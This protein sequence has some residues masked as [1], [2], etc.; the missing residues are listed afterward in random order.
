MK[1]YIVTLFVSLLT[2]A[3]TFAQTRGTGGVRRGGSSLEIR[4][5]VKERLKT[6]LNLTDSQ[7][8]SVAAIQQTYEFKIRALKTDSNMNEE[9]RK[10]KL[11]EMEAERK[12]KLKAILSDEQITKLDSFMENRRKM[13]EDRQGMQTYNN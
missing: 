4:E 3:A 11:A 10:T 2:V 6:E 13:R 7:T 9:D 1:K 5:R 12:Q 8:D